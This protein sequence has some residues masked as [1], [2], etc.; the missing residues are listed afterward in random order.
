MK[1]LKLPVYLLLLLEILAIIAGF[2]LSEYTSVKLQFGE[3]IAL[4]AGFTLTALLTLVI[5]FRGQ[6][7]EPSSQTMHSLVAMSLKFLAELIIAFAWFFGA[8]KT[9]LPAVLLFFVLYLSFTLFT[10]L[11]ILKTLKNKSL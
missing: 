4:S 10:V 5:F 7:K 3:I 6:T 2:L 8:K 11:I 9:G 1:N